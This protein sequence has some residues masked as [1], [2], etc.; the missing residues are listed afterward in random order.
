MDLH[1]HAQESMDWL[2]E[3]VGNFYIRIFRRTEKWR[4]VLP[5]T[6]A[7]ESWPCPS[8]PSASEAG[9]A[10]GPLKV[11]FHDRPSPVTMAPES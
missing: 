3:R 10:L 9:E 1:G 11:W 8:D 6:K 4:V 2:P 7:K 5:E